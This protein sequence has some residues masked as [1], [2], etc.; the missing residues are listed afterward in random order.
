MERVKT[1]CM[2][3]N[4]S[5]FESK[6]NV[7]DGKCIYKGCTN[8]RSSNFLGKANQDDGS[9]MG[10]NDPIASNYDQSANVNDGSCKYGP[11][12]PGFNFQADYYY[13]ALVLMAVFLCILKRR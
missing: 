10:C 7:H 6:A 3:E 11:R 1:G 8:S 9:C 4:A 12:Q 5:N 2:E 13:V